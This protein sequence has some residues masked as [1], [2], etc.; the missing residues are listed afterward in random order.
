MNPF[1]YLIVLA[2]GGSTLM[3]SVR[4]ISEKNE[5][6]VESL[7]QYSKKLTP[8]FN[9]IIPFYDK[10][11]YQA[12]TREKVLDIPPQPCI[13]KDNVLINA[14]AVIYWRIVDLEKAYY[15][16]ENLHKAIQ[17]LVL[18]QIRSEM[19]KLELDQTF[20]ARQE[21]NETLLR[22][23]DIAT[24][25]WGVK[26]L[27][28]E[29][30]DITPSKAVQ[31][32][33]ELQMAAERKKRAAILTSEGERDSAINSAQGKAEAQLLD[34][35]AQ[36]KAAILRAEAH[37]QQEVLKAQAAARSLDILS[38]KLRNDPQA[39]PALQYILTQS[40]LEMGN[41]IG[42]SP[43]SKVMFLDPNNIV[44]TLQGMQ[45]VIGQQDHL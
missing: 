24:D 40:Y 15:K 28:V 8:G 45:N 4:I 2:L 6:L 22:E 35:E 31:D 12:T 26:V 19:G 14:D 32:S 29:L 30:R 44:A 9:F 1:L 11:V 33:M 43:S 41:Q 42:T 27:R 7:G 36:K 23:L 39:M 37:A 38:E 13:T 10:V 3:G 18:T 34:A 20:T 17:N 16:V 25:P 21:V 5:A